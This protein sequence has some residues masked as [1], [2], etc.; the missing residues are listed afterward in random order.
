[1]SGLGTPAGSAPR[2]SAPAATTDAAQ[3]IAFVHDGL[4]LG[5][6][7][8]LVTDRFVTIDPTTEP[9]ASHWA[10]QT[11]GAVMNVLFRAPWPESC[12]VSPGWPPSFLP[13]GSCRGVQLWPGRHWMAVWELR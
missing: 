1:M 12:L 8:D 11:C 13:L 9:Q 3:C 5:Q 2:C 7:E 4:D 10:R 6:I